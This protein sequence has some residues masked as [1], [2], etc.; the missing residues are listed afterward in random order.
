M[1]NKKIRVAVVTGGTRGIGAAIA[2]GLQ[3][4][5]HTVAVTYHG[6]EKAAKAYCYGHHELL[7]GLSMGFADGNNRSC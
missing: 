6:D 1:P 3:K 5:G 4:A 7:D 2:E